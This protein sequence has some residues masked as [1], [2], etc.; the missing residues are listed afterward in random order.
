MNLNQNEKI[1]VDTLICK[2]TNQ[3][4]ITGKTSNKNIFSKKKEVSFSEIH[5]IEIMMHQGEEN[6]LKD[7]LRRNAREE[8]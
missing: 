6:R 8:R 4:I 2:L 5:N 1:L 3:R 7:Y